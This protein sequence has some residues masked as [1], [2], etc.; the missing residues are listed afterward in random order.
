MFT[1]ILPTFNER[2]NLENFV[3]SLLRVFED[4]RLDGSI[5]VVDD[6]SPDGTGDIADALAERHADISVLHRP[7]KQG[8]G[9]AYIAGF[10]QALQSDTPLIFEMD[11]DFSHNP[12][13]IP[14]MLEAARDADLV[15]GSRYVPGGGVEN[16]GLLRRLISR[17][18]G[19]YAKWI[20]GVP[21]NDLTGGFKCFRREVLESLDLDS[22]SSYGYGFQIEV[23]YRTLQQGFRVREVPI[24][25]CDRQQ[26]QSKM[27][28]GIVFE[29]M[30]QVWRLRL[31]G[32]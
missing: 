25:F 21:V 32:D 30:A 11:C 16:W 24:T 17:G 31:G 9:P 5:L 19:L 18:G 14:R 3:G 13:Y 1:I 22:I 27:S 29:A 20:P 2:E 26:G 15:L 10:K 6:S 12:V 28:K 23:T 8:L 4:N 7:Q